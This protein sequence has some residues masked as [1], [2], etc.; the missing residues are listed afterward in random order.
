MI[1]LNLFGRLKAPWLKITSYITQYIS[2]EA[3]NF[4]RGGS[5]ISTSFQAFFLFFGRINL[6]MIEKQE[7]LY[8][9]SGGMV[10]RKILKIYML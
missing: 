2:G 9:G 10:P 1:F 6:Q 5:I 3:R 8:G 7:R 4:K